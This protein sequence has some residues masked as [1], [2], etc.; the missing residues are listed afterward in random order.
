MAMADMVVNDSMILF[1]FMN[2]MRLKCA[3]AIDVVRKA[4]P[5][6]FRAILLT[7]ITTF[8]GLTPLLP[9]T[10]VQAQVLIPMA[11]SLSFEVLFS[12]GVI[13][14][15]V[16][17]VN[18]IFEDGIQGIAALKRLLKQAGAVSSAFKTTRWTAI[19]PSGNAACIPKIAIAPLP[20]FKATC[21][22]ND[23]AMSWSTGCVIK[24]DRTAGSPRPAAQHFESARESPSTLQTVR[25]HQHLGTREITKRLYQRNRDFAQQKFPSDDAAMILFKV[26]E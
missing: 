25:K 19:S 3:S 13:L 17:A 16:P 15:V 20:C 24:T 4:G 10:G 23:P 5:R 22:K 9:E 7:S 14:F 21:R 12:A 1:D 8:T 11:I 26:T 6:R 2:R 18:L